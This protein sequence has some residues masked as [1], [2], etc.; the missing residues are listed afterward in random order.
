[1]ENHCGDIELR[2]I[3]ATEE[4]TPW[5]ANALYFIKEEGSNCMN[6]YLT[7]PQ[8]QPIPLCSAGGESGTTII[9]SPNGSIKVVGTLTGYNIELSTELT[10]LIN[11]ALQQGDSISNLINNVGYITLADLP[12]SYNTNL[13]YNPTT[14]TIEND[15]G[16]NATIPLA[17]P[18]VPGLITLQEIEDLIGSGVQLYEGNNTPINTPPPTYNVADFY[19]EK[20]VGGI[21]LQLWQWVGMEWKKVIY[22]GASVDQDNK[23]KLLPIY[24]E[25][26]PTKENLRVGINFM[27][28][29]TVTDK[30]VVHFLGVKRSSTDTNADKTVRFRVLGKGKGGYGTGFPIPIE[31]VNSI[32][33]MFVNTLTA[34]DIQSLSNT[35]TIDLGEIGTTPIEDALNTGSFVE[36]G[37]PNYLYILVQGTNLGV[38]RSYKFIG[39]AGTYGAGGALTATYLDF[40]L[41]PNENVVL[42][43]LPNNIVEVFYSDLGASSVDDVSEAQ[44]ESYVTTQGFG[45]RQN[46]TIKVIDNL[47]ED[48]KTVRFKDV[49]D[50]QSVSG[51]ARV[52][53]YYVTT[54][55]GGTSNL[56][57]DAT[58]Q[59]V[60]NT[61]GTGF[62]ITL[63]DA[64]N[65]GLVSPSQVTTW[66]DKQNALGFTPENVANKDVIPANEASVTKYPSVKA[67]VDYLVQG[68]N[69][70]IPAKTTEIHD[71]DAVIFFNN[72]DSGK[73]KTRTWAQLKT[74]LLSVF[75]KK[76]NQIP[77]GANTTIPDTWDGQTIIFT[78]SC[79]ITVPATLP[80]GFGFNF[81]VK[82]GATVTWAITTPHVWAWGTPSPT[83]EKT[84]GN[85]TKEG[86]TNNIILGT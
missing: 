55:G 9:K 41:I 63:V 58:T 42:Q 7:T 14:H 5:V 74:T 35:Q 83:N 65:A 51:K 43:P 50:S 80:A 26:E 54:S 78:A 37:D 48:F 64:F 21:P 75:Q 6:I 86:S 46:L 20:T 84:Y 60:S 17:S 32:D 4:P 77:I 76:D 47:S 18:T 16:T 36:I 28:T 44:V 61:N 38:L 57:Y 52:I 33:I 68:W 15:N 56:S 59:T 85:F 66:N 29:I 71:T 70:I 62:T 13:N 12:A 40:E 3:K 39:A 23:A 34:S 25:G 45:D 31:N 69:A 11:T 1:M 67:V 19:I 53:S 81:I 2:F 49:I 72:T 73:T 27:P 82:I 8:R 79:T 24:Y 10:N 30:E 22:G